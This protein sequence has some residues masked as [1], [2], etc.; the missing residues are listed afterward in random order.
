M[1]APSLRNVPIRPACVCQG[2]LV[3]QQRDRVRRRNLAMSAARVIRFLSRIGID[4]RWPAHPMDVAMLALAFLVPAGADDAL[5][6]EQALRSFETEPGFSVELVAAEPLTV[7]PVALAFDDRGRLFVA[8]DRDYPVGSPDGRALGVVALLEDTDGDGRMDRRTEFVTGIAF[9]NGV[10][11]WREGVIVTAAPEVSWFVDTDGDGKSD[12]KEVLL[13]G[14]DTSSTSQLRV[15]DPTLGPDGWI[16]LAGG[17]RGGRI[18]SPRHPERILD[19]EKS[20]LRFRPDTGE[21]EPIAGKSQFGL[22]FNDAGDRFACMNRVQCQ[23]APLPLRYLARNPFA[24]SPGALQDCPEI[25]ANNLMTQYTAG[26]ARIFP[27][28]D[29]VTTADSHEGTYTAAC[30]IHVYRGAALPA[31]YRGAAFSCDPTGNLVRGDR[32][33]PVGGTFAARR[34]HENTEALRSRDNWFRPV[35]L[36]EGPD[37]ALYIADMYRRTIEHPEYLPVEIREHT[38]FEG[39]KD[40]G[41]IWRLTGSQP[42]KTVASQLSHGLLTTDDPAGAWIAELNSSIPWR[43]DTAF[44]L[45]L[46]NEVAPGGRSVS[47][48]EPEHSP[49]QI[50]A[51]A[52]SRLRRLLERPGVRAGAVLELRLLALGGGLDGPT[53]LSALD[54]PSAAVRQNAVKL[55][56]PLLAN[57][58]A[59][60][61]RV[62]SLAD[63]PDSHVRFQVAL[64]LGEVPGADIVPAL[65]RIAVRQGSDRWTRAAIVCSLTDV[66]LVSLLLDALAREPSPLPA[67]LI[68]LARD[69]GRQLGAQPNN[70]ARTAAISSLWARLESAPIPWTLAA[71]AGLAVADADAFR[72]IAGTRPGSWRQLLSLARSQAANAAAGA[73]LRRCAIELLA[74][75]D[76]EED[77]RVL[78]ELLEPAQP[79]EIQVAA[80]RSLAV[81]AHAAALAA[82]L[83]PEK[84]SELAPGVRSVV[85]SRLTARP[86]LTA[87]LLDAL[88]AGGVP[89]NVLSPRQREALRLLPDGALRS[90][91]RRLLAAPSDDRE[92]AYLA[93]RAALKLAANPATGRVVFEAHCATCH[94]LDRLGVPVGPDLFG[95]RNQPRE[96]ILYH[97]IVP[98]AEIAPNFVN[99]E[100]ELKDGGMLSGL[101]VAESASS[102][103]LR[104]AQGIEEVVPRSNIARLTASRLSLMPQELEKSM[105]LQELAD[106][107][108]YVRGESPR[109]VRRDPKE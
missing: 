96:T 100:C 51:N 90:R 32:L 77:G 28:S 17:L 70:D 61:D 63:D 43:R 18:L 58:A 12:H 85:V 84:W 9:P 6:P 56:E 92:K 109:I 16:Y 68:E 29:N 102:V 81:A 47:T 26:A 33:E 13:T 20:D 48:V 108:A 4:T 38:D 46:E 66:S 62:L 42:A 45:L 82:I 10:L 2:G 21:L 101:L 25:T 71:T 5:P 94:R 22:S 39:G 93:T 54:H 97:I 30:G 41:R 78:S 107:I 34:I 59:L 89:V 106:L 52:A 98:E 57:A 74:F 73:A 95:I 53:L 103:T 15:N 86:E 27:I 55:A 75:D 50:P 23:H 40:R 105:S 36:A 83:T 1:N 79:V 69:L 37:G 60:R 31:E 49:A 65:A 14:F 87:I 44:R 104:M 76:A 7:D 24:V 99:Y 72:R 3:P 8:E 80:A 88:E 91:A 11:P 64:S 19:T 35:F 67:G